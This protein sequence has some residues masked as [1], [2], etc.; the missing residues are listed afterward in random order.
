[1]AAAWKDVEQAEPEF[2]ARVRRLFKA[3]RHKTIAPLR[4]DGS[5]RI[6]G[7]DCMAR[8]FTHRRA[9]GRVAG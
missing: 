3:G 7:I 1:M 6:S 2:V 5:L 9:R 8:R 4:A